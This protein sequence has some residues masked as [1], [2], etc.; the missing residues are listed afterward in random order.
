MSARPLGR[1]RGRGERRGS[2]DPPTPGRGTSFMSLQTSHRPGGAGLDVG[3]G[4]GVTSIT[5]R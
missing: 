2:T 1:G 5:G 3:Q 4:P